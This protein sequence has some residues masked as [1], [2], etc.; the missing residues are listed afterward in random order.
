M[1]YSQMRCFQQGERGMI[2]FAAA[3]IALTTLI[4]SFAFAQDATPKVQVFGGYSLLQLDHGGL[5]GG[6]LDLA[7]KQNSDPFAVANY[8]LNGWNAQAQYNTGR[9]VG[10]AADFGGR[11]GTPITASRDRTLAGL[12]KETAYSFLAGPVI[13]YRTKSPIT[14]FVHGLFGWDRTSLGASTITG[15][16]TS[17]VPVAGTTYNDFAMA[18]GGGVDYR[19]GRRVSLRLGQLDWFHTSLDLNKFYSSAF[20]PGLIFGLHTHEAN[21]RFSAGAVV[22]F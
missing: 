8:F 17:P 6:L 19:V 9:W 21:L 16:V 18:L 20:G 15:S 4:G 7:L 5:N 10:I 13:S 14:P 2:R 3:A 1:R 11:Y 22:R 12:P